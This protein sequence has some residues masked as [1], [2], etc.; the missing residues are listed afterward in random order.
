MEQR[1][2]HESVLLEEAIS[3][4]AI[5][6]D[7]IYV[8]ATFG[9]GGHSDAILSKLGEKGRLVVFDRDP[10]A[11]EVANK[12]AAT[13]SRVEVVRSAF[14]ELGSVI[15][16]LG[17]HGKVN[18]VLF[19]LGVS[20]PQ[21]DNPDR[22][23]SFMRS[24]PLDMRMDPDEGVSAQ[25]WINSAREKD[26]ADVIY[27]YGEERHSRR[28]ARKIIEERTESPITD[29]GRLAE[30]IK[31]ANPAWERD[32][33]PATRAF[34]GIRIFINNE[35]GEIESG[36]AQALGCLKIEGRLVVISFHSLEDRIVKK[37]ISRQ[38]KGDNFPRD[39]PVMSSELSPTLKSIGKAAKAKPQEVSANPRARS[40][41][42]RVAEK[43]SNKGLE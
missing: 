27:K 2:H 29:T 35:F 32:K 13:D 42:L 10:D 6:R 17:L 38:T 1:S 43:I 9:R 24:G 15:E 14:S 8:D 31:H 36:I 11:I 18:G 40:A 33:H 12:L 20:S 7:G 34:Q 21:L 30:I 26:I 23:F 19:D 22:G 5:V 16:T 3:G 25:Q 4:L 37:F 41:V 28:M 39:L